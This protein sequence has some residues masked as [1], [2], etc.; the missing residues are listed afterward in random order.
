MRDAWGVCARFA[1]G[2]GGW[3]RHPGVGTWWGRGLAFENLVEGLGFIGC[4]RG[5]RS[6]VFVRFLDFERTENKGFLC[7]IWLP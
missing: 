4:A 1:F 3:T 2:K 7:S 5:G 6:S